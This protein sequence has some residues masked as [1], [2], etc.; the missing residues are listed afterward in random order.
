MLRE[1]RK[2]CD[3]PLCSRSIISCHTCSTLRSAPPYF[4]PAPLCFPL[5]SHALLS[6]RLT[7]RLCFVS[8]YLLFR[9]QFKTF[10]LFFPPIQLQHIQ[11]ARTRPIIAHYTNFYFIIIIIVIFLPSGVKIPRVKSKVISKRK[12]EVVTPRR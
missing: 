3:L 10:L 2:S 9:N 1:R 5:R 7:Q 8:V 11:H 4:L 6:T 12:A